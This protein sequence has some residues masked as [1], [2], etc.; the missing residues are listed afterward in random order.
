MMRIE[1]RKTRELVGEM[2]IKVLIR[3]PDCSDR[4]AWFHVNFLTV[5]VGG[6]MDI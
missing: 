1:P 5:K 2:P 6:K 3:G 4:L